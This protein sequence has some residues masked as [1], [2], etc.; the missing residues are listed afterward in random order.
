MTTGNII[1]SVIVVTHNS[2]SWIR[3]CLDSLFSQEY[4][5]P[6]EILVVDNGSTDQTRLII[7][8]DFPD[9]LLIECENRGFGAGNNLGAQSAKGTYLAFINPDTV[10]D[11]RWLAELVRPLAQPGLVTTSKILLMDE[12]ELINTCGMTL[13]FTG[14]GFVNKYRMPAQT[15][16]QDF[17]VNGISG[18]AFAMRK[19]DFDRLGG[20]DEDFFMYMEDVDFSWRMLKDEITILCIVQSEVRHRYALNISPDKIAALEKGR[21]LLL[22]KH[23]SRKQ[24]LILGPSLCL[25]FMLSLLK[26]QP[27]SAR[28]IQFWRKAI[29]NGLSQ[30]IRPSKAG[31]VKLDTLSDPIPFMIFSK[32]TG[33]IWLGHASNYLLNANRLWANLV[34]P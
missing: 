5:F 17:E 31:G 1:T 8:H 24:L 11:P 15:I 27:F 6:Y 19:Q 23:L 14:F 25:S 13:H 28:G 2:E 33:I 3:D 18:A 21:I 9:A 34:L 7:Q 26:C 10:A 32:N 4:D 12:P 20:F 22:R 30:P 29:K 16:T